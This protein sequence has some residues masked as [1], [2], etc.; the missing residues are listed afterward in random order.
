MTT[1]KRD[2]WGIA[3]EIHGLE[4]M[5]ERPGGCELQALWGGA[6]LRGQEVSGGEKQPD[7]QSLQL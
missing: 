1:M 3:L 6:E 4:R 5:L 2:N 7:E